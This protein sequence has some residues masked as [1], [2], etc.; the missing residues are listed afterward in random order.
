MGKTATAAALYS[1][2][3][4][5]GAQAWMLTQDGR[6][7]SGQGGVGFG[8]CAASLDSPPSRSDKNCLLWKELDGDGDGDHQVGKVAC[9]END[10]KHQRWKYSEEVSS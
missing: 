6:I 7:R 2:H 4:Q 1:C 10:S 8:C 9:T 3:K 5:G